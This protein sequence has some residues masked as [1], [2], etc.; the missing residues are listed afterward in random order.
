MTPQHRAATETAA[1]LALPLSGGIFPRAWATWAAA[2]ATSFALIETA[3]LLS[4]P[5][6]PKTLSAQ[7]RRRRY[8][9]G[10]LIGVGAAW[11][12]HHIIWCGE[13]E[14]SRD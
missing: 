6:G 5:P 4:E 1:D 12:I 2:V 10:A 7:L 11:L 8:L 3:A 13:D 14:N 9:S